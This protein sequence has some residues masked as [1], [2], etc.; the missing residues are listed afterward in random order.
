MADY[1]SQVKKHVDGEHAVIVIDNSDITKPCSPKMEA[2]SDVRDGST[3]E[4]QKGYSTIEAAVLSKGKKVPMPVY[5]KVFPAAEEDFIS[6]TYENLCCLRALSAS[7]SRTCVRTLDCCF[8][9]NEYFKYF[10]KN[11]EKFVIR[12]KKNRNVIYGG[13]TKNVMEV[14]NKYKRNYKMDFIDKH[15]K[16]LN[17]KSVISRCSCVNS[18]RRT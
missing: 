4:I 14:A 17:V 1:I 7:F 18:Q 8:D 9:A 12:L 11:N 6:E 10:L 15:G 3:V 2:V 13:N 5:E 16:K